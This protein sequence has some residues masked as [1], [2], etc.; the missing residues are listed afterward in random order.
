MI[1]GGKRLEAL[2]AIVEERRLGSFRFMPY[3]ERDKLSY[4][5]GV[6][7]VHWLSLD[8]KLEG[9]IVPSK[10]YGVA[11]A[12]RPVVVIGDKNGEL[13]PLVEKYHCGTAIAPGDAATLV[14]T[15]RRWSLDPEAV[16]Q[17]GERARR[18]LD[19]RFTQRQGLQR[20][21]DLIDRLS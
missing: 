11:A 7:D 15:L 19:I 20:W 5:L 12:G 13:A 14:E 16:V 17:M 9:L 6:A 18:M 4:S 10:F 2:R 3:Q 8:P 1:G 21:C